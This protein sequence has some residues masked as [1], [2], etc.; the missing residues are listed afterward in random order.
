MIADSRRGVADG[1]AARSTASS[2]APTGSP[3]T[4]TPRTRSARTRSPCSRAH[5]GIP[6][7]V[8]APTSTVDLATPTGAEIPIEE[9]AGDEV[10][11][12]FAARNPAFDV[13]P[14]GA[15]RGDRHRA[16]RP[17]RA[18]RASR[19]RRSS[20]MKALI[21]AAGYATRLRPL[22]DSIPKQ[23]LPVGGRPMLDWIL[24]QL[25]DDRRRRDPPRHERAL[26]RRLRALGRGQGRH[27]PQRRDD[28]ERGPPRRDRRH[29]L[30][31]DEP[32]STTTCS[33][34][35]ATTSS[36]TRSRDYV[37]LARQAQR[38]LRRRATTSATGS[39]ARSTASSTST[40]TIG[41]RLRREARA[42]PTTTLAATATYLYARDHA[43]LVERRIS[44]RAT[45]PTSPATSSRGST[46]ACP[47]TRTAS[48]GEWFDIGD[49]G[50]LLEAD[51]RSAGGRAAEREAYAVD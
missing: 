50:Q 12:R 23:L 11:A 7:Y 43:R 25:R 1:R 31:R 34:S 15:D 48:E 42:A 10:T 30:R 17:P 24:D 21:L 32:G 9:R 2:P 6:L 45:R 8:V 20:L 49:H 40:S 37:R 35:P 5:H 26:R 46:R 3:R 51:N 44:T 27:G 29:P 14:A 22:T 33:S 28:V 4:A 41:R 13:T 18:V 39:S 36:T 16:R 38:Q 47:S 19:S